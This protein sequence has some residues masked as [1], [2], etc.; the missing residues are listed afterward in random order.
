MNLKNY[1]AKALYWLRRYYDRCRAL[2]EVGDSFPVSTAFTSI[3]AEAYERA[4]LPYSPVEQVPGIPYVCLRLPTGGGKTLV[5]CEAIPIVQTE[6]LRL[7]HSLILWLVPSDAIRKQTLDR[8]KDRRDPYRIALETSLDSV[9]VLD[10]DEALTIQRSVLDGATV[11]IVATMQAFRRKDVSALLVNRNNGA[12]MSHFENLPSELIEVLDRRPEGDFDYSLVNVFRLRRPFIIIDEAHNA[13]QPLSF[14]TLKRLNP[15]GILELTATPNT[16]SEIVTYEGEQVEN[17]PSNVLYSV[18]AYALKAEQMIKLPIYLRFREPWDALLGDAIA[19]LNKLKDEAEKEEAET[20]EYIRPIMLLQAQPHFQNRTS[21]TVETVKST[22]VN[23]FHIPEEQIA[24]ATGDIRDLDKPENQNVLSPSCKLRFIITV[25]ALKEGWDCPFAY[26]LFSVAEL[27]SGRAVEQILGRILRMPQAR[28]KVREELNNSYAF[29]ASTRF[30]AAARA[31][32]EGLVHAGFEKQE[33]DDLIIEQSLPF[34]D[35]KVTGVRVELQEPIDVTLPISLKDPLP[36]SV[37]DAVTWDQKTQVL[38]IEKTLSEEQTTALAASLVDE[39]NREAFVE[40]L[41]MRPQSYRKEKSPSEL[42]EIFE[43]PVL[44]LKQGNLLQQFEADDLNEHIEWSLSDADADLSGFMIPDEKRGIKI[45]ITDAEKLKQDFITAGDAQLKLLQISTEWPLGE[46][47][48]WLDRSFVHL[49]LTQAETGVY[50][51]RLIGRLIENRAFTG[52]TLTAHRHRL[53]KAIEAKIRLL[54]REA[55]R[56]ALEEL[57][58]RDDTTVFVEA[59][60]SH[61]FSPYKYPITSPYEGLPLPRHYYPVIGNLQSRGEEYDCARTIAS[62]KGIKFWLRNIS[63]EPEAS[64]WIQT[65]TDKFY[66]DFVC[67]LMNGKNL[68]VE[69][70]AASYGDKAD[71]DEKERLGQLWAARSKGTCLFLIIKG[72]SELSKIGD[73]VHKSLAVALNANFVKLPT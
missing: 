21:I 64:F 4:G 67:K 50:L 25:Q 71:T 18:T 47:V 45:D 46:L 9:E 39:T 38:R 13:R 31:L 36:L 61:L 22:L 41:G 40:A 62:T 63:R 11:I 49:D 23:Q 60:A 6:L 42:G 26:V 1:Q 68:I 34:A 57:L 24:I 48:N 44:A 43:V 30:D 33:V 20:R 29:V 7:E 51:T 73:L 66:P 16:K 10:I 52:E 72:P 5:G 56:H 3:T 12:L 17:P 28:R 15:S 70:K 59:A 8:L 53:S 37:I 65:S 58:F 54:R 35:A 69:Y 19:L 27:S 2:Q 32:K 55:R 14:E